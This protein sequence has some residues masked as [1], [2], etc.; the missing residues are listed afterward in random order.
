[1]TQRS[2]CA[3]LD[4]APAPRNE[5]TMPR[6]PADACQL[7]QAVQQSCGRQFCTCQ[8]SLCSLVRG[9]APFFAFPV[10]LL[11][12]LPRLGQHIHAPALFSS[13]SPLFHHACC[14]P[15]TI[16][17][18]DHT[19]PLPSTATHTAQVVTPLHVKRSHWQQIMPARLLT[20]LQRAPPQAGDWRAILVGRLLVLHLCW[21]CPGCPGS[22]LEAAASIR[23]GR[24]AG[25]PQHPSLP[26]AAPTG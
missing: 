8:A 20:L 15:L 4:C 7:A 23:A 5:W 9:P 17:F 24:P 10:S 1:M 6:L 3:K 14:C 22:C 13:P 26:A 19:P 21:C 12:S 11:S 2:P 18:P 25:P 16:V